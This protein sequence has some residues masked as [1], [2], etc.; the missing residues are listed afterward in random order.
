MQ[1]AFVTTVAEWINSDPENLLGIRGLKAKID[2][3]T[4]VL[5]YEYRPTM[6]GTHGE[7]RFRLAQWIESAPSEAQKQLMFLLLEHLFF[8]GKHEFDAMYLT[9]FSRHVSQWIMETES[10]QLCNSSAF[11]QI[12]SA[13]RQTL[14]TAITDSFNIG[15][16]IRVNSIQ[17]AN[18]RFVWEQALRSKWDP[19]VFSQG[20][21]D[22]KNRIVLLEDFVGSGS[23]MEAAVV[24]ACSLPSQPYVLLCPLIICPDGGD[25]ARDLLQ[26]FNNLS[27]RPVLEL[28]RCNFLTPLGD[29]KEPALFDKIR[30][31][32]EELH[33]QVA[34]HGQ[35]LQNYGPYGYRDTG[36]L[37]VKYDNCPDNTLPLFHHRSDAPWNPLFFRVSREAL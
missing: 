27:Y 6:A 13:E 21:M 23:Q 2:Y 36:A 9:A 12:K 30:T 1:S 18:M 22:G 25:L 14:F 33:P 29:A 11:G 28:H 8:V 24:A 17:G 32:V 34:G 20:A 19:A 5:Y 37:I 31:L 26:R 7:F 35:W 3:L 16:F 15:D 4:D 10:I